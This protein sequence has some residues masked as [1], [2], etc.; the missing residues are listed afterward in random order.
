ML[1]KADKIMQKTLKKF[2]KSSTTK[3]KK[4]T[5]HKRQSLD[6]ENVC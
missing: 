3:K 2:G 1:Q 4:R 5:I 6:K